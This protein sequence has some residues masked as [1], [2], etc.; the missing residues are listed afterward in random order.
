LTDRAFGVGGAFI[1]AVR[2]A[3][4]FSG[5]R[6]ACGAALADLPYSEGVV[7]YGVH[8]VDRRCFAGAA[9]VHVGAASFSLSCL[10]FAVAASNLSAIVALVAFGAD[11][12]RGARRASQ[13]VVATV[14]SAGVI[15]G[16]SAGSGNGAGP[17]DGAEGA[18]LFARHLGDAV[19]G[20]L[21]SA[22]GVG[23]GIAGSGDSGR[24]G[25]ADGVGG[26]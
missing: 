14:A 4:S 22:G 1:E 8:A 7:A 16:G 10:V 15:G 6:R 11:G 18:S 20:T 9:S 5:A 23:G 13:G 12:A 3:V 17:A 2:I 26:A 25:I 24:I 19:V 21:A